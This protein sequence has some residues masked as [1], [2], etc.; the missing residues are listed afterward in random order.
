M[1]NFLYQNGGNHPVAKQYMKR[2][3]LIILLALAFSIHGYA[4]TWT[5]QHPSPQGNTLNGVAFRDDLEG[6][7]VGDFGTIIK[8]TNGG[9]VWKLLQSNTA[10]TLYAVAISPSDAKFVVACGGSNTYVVSTNAGASWTPMTVTATGPLCTWRSICFRDISS[11]VYMCGDSGYI[12]YSADLAQTFQV[13]RRP[14]PPPFQ[15]HL[16]S[17]VF[18]PNSQRGV[19]V[20]DSST[21]CVTSNSGA[22]WATV[23]QANYPQG[24]VRLRGTCVPV[25][26]SS[27][28]MYAT[29][30]TPSSL[31]VVW[32]S[33]DDG[34]KWTA[35][36]A[37]SNQ[38]TGIAIVP[39]STRTLFATT[40][41]GSLAESTTGGLTWDTDAGFAALSVTTVLSAVA[42]SD[43][44]FICVVANNGRIFTRT[45][46]DIPRH[47]WVERDTGFYNTLRDVWFT[48]KMNG[49]AVGDGGAAALTT[50]GGVRWKDIT[51]SGAAN[52][53]GVGFSD[54]LHGYVCDDAGK[55]FRTQDG[56]NTWSQQPTPATTGITCVRAVDD[57]NA[58][59]G[60]SKGEVMQT[61]N[62]GG[63]WIATQLPIYQGIVALQFLSKDYGWALTQHD[64][65]FSTTDAGVTWHASRVTAPVS[66]I[67]F[68]DVAFTDLLNGWIV[69][70]GVMFRTTDGGKSWRTNSTF[71]P[72]LSGATINALGVVDE[73][74]A[75]CAG[76]RG[77]I[78]LATD[79]GVAWNAQQSSTN[80]QLL[81]LKMVNLENGWAVGYNGT[82]LK[83][84]DSHP[85]LTPP[86]VVDFGKVAFGL[87]KDTTVFV[88]NSGGSNLNIMSGNVTEVDPSGLVQF[89][90]MTGP[91]PIPIKPAGDSV[92]IRFGPQKS[93]PNDATRYRAGVMTLTT[94]GNV[95]TPTMTLVGQ[96][97]LSTIKFAGSADHKFNDT[98][99]GKCE[100]YGYLIMNTGE[101]AVTLDATFIP[102]NGSS[103]TPFH[104]MPQ[105]KGKV[106]APGATDTMWVE[107]CPDSTLLDTARITIT[108]VPTPISGKVFGR[109]V[110]LIVKITNPTQCIDFGRLKDY[111]DTVITIE[112]VGNVDDRV[113]VVVRPS[114]P[115]FT[116]RAI[117]GFISGNVLYRGSHQVTFELTP[118]KRG[119]T[120]DST[121]I[122][123]IDKFGDPLDSICAHWCY[124][125]QNMCDYD[126]RFKCIPVLTCDSQRV[127]LHNCGDS[128]NI[129]RLS[130]GG[131]AAHA[132]SW[133]PIEPSVLTF[134]HAMGPT[135]S[136]VVWYKFCPGINDVG[137]MSDATLSAFYPDSDGLAYAAGACGVL[138]GL[139]Y[140][141][142]VPP[143]CLDFGD[144]AQ[145]QVP[146][147]YSDSV[148]LV[149]FGT[150]PLDVEL[151]HSTKDSTVFTVVPSG[152]FTVAP[153]ETKSVAVTFNPPG[154][155]VYFD[156]LV[157]HAAQTDQ[158]FHTCL[159]GSTFTSG[160]KWYTATRCFDTALVTTT[161]CDTGIIENTGTSPVLIKSWT[162][163]G[164]T[165]EFGAP[166]VLEGVPHTLAPGEKMHVVFCYTPQSIGPHS[167]DVTFTTDLATTSPKFT[168]CG[169]AYATQSTSLV[170]EANPIPVAAPDLGKP[171][172]NVA[173]RMTKAVDLSPARSFRFK[174]TYDKSRLY[175]DHID[176]GTLIAGWNPAHVADTGSVV[177]SFSGSTPL[178]G[179]G[180][181]ANL[182]FTPY[183]GSAQTTVVCFD[184]AFGLKFNIAGG[185]ST[186]P[187]GTVG[188]CVDVPF[189]SVC[190]IRVSNLVIRTGTYLYQSAPNPAA[191]FANVPFQTKEAGHVTLRV[192]NTYGVEVARLVDGDVSAGYREVAFSTAALPEGV[193]F[194][195]L[196]T[197][198]TRIVRRL[199]V[200]K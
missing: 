12:V 153:T 93:G 73:G 83:Y 60:T 115:Q 2:V 41:D 109:G 50:T 62:A 37:L 151:W 102:L 80:M 196:V 87:T 22:T 188:A 169:V 19:A 119:K 56:G 18:R 14:P 99:V 45:D 70:N 160:L 34:T 17:M 142:P 156:T 159:S 104:L 171:S 130:I 13:Q 162:I 139:N 54:P 166:Q 110:K 44:G 183:Y 81:G 69:G 168:R 92:K 24:L 155:G 68:Y 33:T 163:T 170:L 86:M 175:L 57:V 126:V 114:D 112:N 26:V 107:Y 84:S 85:S 136:I 76:L 190:G 15:G 49:V 150:A 10:A 149:N 158:T 120:C 72:P 25:R 38:Y 90:M 182:V 161:Q 105:S 6:Y 177:V 147:T 98:Y 91:Y 77:A 42:L 137:D 31:G 51:I 118:V 5:W 75:W 123:F 21:I 40:M 187:I 30:S 127:V 74:H 46:G 16:W 28:D 47:V 88:A 143:T 131:K 27:S 78:Y 65:L 67:N 199:L 1:H 157:W 193:Y 101:I 55:M 197:P 152:T 43:N 35:L 165:G 113:D 172:L 58:W 184:T 173:V 96:G 20:G 59:A 145:T 108:G 195:E 64:T 94:A 103:K 191:G 124:S 174:V 185:D 121:W 9:K 23:P 116:L 148:R 138:R 181:L 11:N 39:G 154:P 48:D 106:I 61:V 53:A 82:I 198:T 79:G 189:D 194:Y 167:I 180:T 176:R 144:V 36:P 179:T 97:A 146:V 117:R 125:F 192:V 129:T 8:T 29:G 178:N 140:V 95:S 4:Q 133:T 52:L 32:K 200:V 128:V 71:N 3:S 134:P 164:N 100:Q 66:S 132:F 63:S 122:V 186:N 111:V 141:G 89:Q 7:I 135:D